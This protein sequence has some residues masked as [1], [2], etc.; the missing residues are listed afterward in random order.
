M[1]KNHWEKSNGSRQKQKFPYRGGGGGA[2]DK[3]RE[4]LQGE[5]RRWQ[6]LSIGRTNFQE[7]KPRGGGAEGGCVPEVIWYPEKRGGGVDGPLS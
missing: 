1:G 5:R 2:F 4:R 6:V 3:S 7:H